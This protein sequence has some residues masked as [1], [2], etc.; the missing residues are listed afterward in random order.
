MLT[1]NIYVEKHQIYKIIVWKLAAE[2][3]EQQSDDSKQ[4]TPQTKYFPLFYC[5]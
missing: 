5:F 3:E 4:N 2:A 1:L